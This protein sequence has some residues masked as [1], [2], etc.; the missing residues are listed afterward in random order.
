MKAI[1][2][3]GIVFVFVLGLG[4]LNFTTL[5]QDWNTPLV[6]VEEVHAGSDCRWGISTCGGALIIGCQK[7]NGWVPYICSPG[8]PSC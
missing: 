4:A 6:G 1:R 3:L 8:C 2:R 7:P 5:V